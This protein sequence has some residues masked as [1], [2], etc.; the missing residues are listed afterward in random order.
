MGAKHELN[1]IH[2]VGSLAA[3]GILGLMTSSIAIFAVAGAVLIGA[4]VYTRDIR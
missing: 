1:K 2:V 4:A 3:A